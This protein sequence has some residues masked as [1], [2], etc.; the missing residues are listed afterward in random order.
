MRRNALLLLLVGILVVL[1]FLVRPG[2]EFAGADGRAEEAVAELRP[3]YRPWVRPLWEPPSS[4]VESLLFA[5]QA[6]L[7]SGLLFYYLGYMKGLQQGVRTLLHDAG[8]E[9][10]GP[11]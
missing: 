3:D 6:A 1:P 10:R 7:G 5:L 11:D 9:D 4:E 8:T 2:A